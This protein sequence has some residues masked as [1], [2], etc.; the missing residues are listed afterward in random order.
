MKQKS[1]FVCQECGYQ[2]PKWQGQCPECQNWNT[3]VE[4]VVQSKKE[5]AKS[6]VVVSAADSESLYEV[7]TKPRDFRK[8]ISTGLGE[9]DRVLGTSTNAEG[10][11][12][13]SGMVPG[14]VVL[15]AGEPGIGKSTLI[16]QTIIN[17]LMSQKE[18][19]SK[20][21]KQAN[22][23]DITQHSILYVNGEENA[24]QIAERIERVYKK[25]SKFST[26]SAGK[27]PEN[28][29][30]MK[31]V[32]FYSSTN[33][34]EVCAM[35]TQTHPFLVVV[36]SI[37]TQKTEDLTGTAGSFGQLKESTQRITETVK[38]LGIP[39]VLIGH[40]TKEGTIA[41]PKVLEHTVDAV[42]ELSGE[43]TGEVRILRAVKNRFG[44]TDEVG[45][46]MIDE[47]GLKELTNPSEIFLQQGEQKVPGSA[48]VCTLE[49][50]R[51][52]LLETQALVVESQLAMPRRVAQGITV[53]RMQVLT[54]VL[55]KHGHIPLGTADVFVNVAGGFQIREPA[56]DLG[57]AMAMVA[58]QKNKTLPLSTVFIGEVGLL[59]EIRE[60]PFLKRRIKEAKRLGFATVISSQSHKHIMQ[61]I[62]QFFGR[63]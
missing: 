5:S 57:I 62:A 50:T 21:V 24:S 30:W 52:L 48:I 33:V 41:G 22:D 15:V 60:V 63:K 54:A 28:N 46:F 13:A 27:K 10:N 18:N 7:A 59:G 35:I 36:D 29:D 19:T 47:D 6:N 31:R 2:S 39:T 20:S 26:S 53:P 45:L 58:S 12:V 9:F 55:Q 14:S 8:R 43:R 11:T 17:I 3:L 16:T 42:L 40:V 61:V 44:A 37:Q 32:V 51:P 23:L 4:Q 1:V 56:A 38:K 49:G 34:D 25:Y